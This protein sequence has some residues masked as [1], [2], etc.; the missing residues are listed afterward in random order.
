VPV[1]AGTGSSGTDLAIMYSKE[2]EEI[3][4][5]AIMAAPPRLLKP[6]D[7]SVFNYYRDIAREV[8]VPIVN[9]DE[10]TTY[11]VHMSPL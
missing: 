3:G 2:A 4:V 7:D 9:Q 5:D 11:G 10:P 1:V 8:D 6:N